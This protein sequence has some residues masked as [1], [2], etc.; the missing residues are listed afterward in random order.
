MTKTQKAIGKACASGAPMVI[1]MNSDDLVS[2]FPSL[3]PLPSPNAA[4]F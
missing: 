2:V 1:P 3:Y 4:A